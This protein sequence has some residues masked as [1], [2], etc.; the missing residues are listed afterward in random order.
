M[1]PVLATGLD[2]LLTEDERMG[3][4]LRGK[5]IGLL[6]NAAS[7]AAGLV[8]APRALLGADYDVRVLFGPE[9]GFWGAAQ[10]ME[11]V[12]PGEPSRL[13]VVSLY[14]S[15]FEELSPRPE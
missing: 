4:I 5:R 14:G 13:P 7:V 9:H 6:A 2:V 3:R 15:T 1:A 10:D 8:P 11:A 12:A